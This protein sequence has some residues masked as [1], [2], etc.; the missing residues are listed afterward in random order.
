MLQGNSTE[1]MRMPLHFVLDPPQW[2]IFTIHYVQSCK[3]L[4][5]TCMHGLL[6]FA[7]VEGYQVCVHLRVCVVCVCA[8]ARV[9]NVH[10]CSVH[11]L[12][13]ARYMFVSVHQ[14]GSSMVYFMFPPLPSVEDLV[15]EWR[16]SLL[17]AD[18]HK[19]VPLCQLTVTRLYLC[20]LT[21]TRLYPCVS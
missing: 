11:V 4:M 19:T 7:S 9:C 13:C 1:W 2:H 6:L 20:Q 8:L 16:Q 15:E 10:M 5:H 14:T 3:C 17:S 21:V 18:S 12:V